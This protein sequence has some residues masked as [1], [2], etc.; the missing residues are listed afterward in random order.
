MGEIL[1]VTVWMAQLKRNNPILPMYLGN[2][3]K[4]ATAVAY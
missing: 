4:V 1:A 3:Y 2:N